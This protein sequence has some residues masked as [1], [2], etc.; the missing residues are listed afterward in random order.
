MKIDI[1]KL[2][3]DAVDAIARKIDLP[4][5]K[6]PGNCYAIAS[7]MIKAGVVKG[8]ARY[9]HYLGEVKKGSMFD[10]GHP[11]IRHGWIESGENGKKIV[12]DPTRWV[13]EG[14]KPYIYIS[15]DLSEYDVG[16]QIW[17]EMTM[18]PVPEFDPK[19]VIEINASKKVN[20]AILDLLG[21]PKITKHGL[22]WIANLPMNRLGGNIK[23]IYKVLEKSGHGALIPI[24]NYSFV[25]GKKND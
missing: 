2:N 12:I 19:D 3:V 13:F 11:V 4:V 5:S 8:V 21:H 17:R 9:G 6:W 16:G 7:M 24:D 1:D 22:F 10:R 25:M 23:G 20:D 15:D 14:K 18:F